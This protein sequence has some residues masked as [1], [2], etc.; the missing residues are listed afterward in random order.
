MNVGSNTDYS[1]VPRSFTQPLDQNVGS[2]LK[3][4][5]EQF[6]PCRFQFLVHKIF[7]P[8]SAVI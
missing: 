7:P 6:L 8:V 5:E 2:S 4:E 3:T 1:D